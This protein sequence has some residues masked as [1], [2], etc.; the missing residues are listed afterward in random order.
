M[1]IVE[2][3]DRDWIQPLPLQQQLELVATISQRLTVILKKEQSTIEQPHQIQNE[4]KNGEFSD[5]AV[6][7][8]KLTYLALHPLLLEKYLGEHIAIHGGELVDHD[9]DGV[10]LS[11]RIYAR[12]PEEFVWIA[13]VKLQPVEEWVVRSP[14][15]ESLAG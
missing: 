13:P 6:E 5:E 4:V 10:A 9:A 2:R 14:R 8:E 1:G 15:F 7:R 12:F 3:I 11:Q